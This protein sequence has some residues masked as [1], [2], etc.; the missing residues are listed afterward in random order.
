MKN[1]IYKLVLI[2]SLFLAVS[3]ADNALDVTPKDANFPFQ[4]ILDTDEGGDLADAEDY[5]IEIKFADYLGN[6][7]SETITLSYAI[8]AEDSFEGIVEIDKVVYEVEIDDCV[9]ERELAFD[10]IAK[11][12]TVVQ[13]QDLESLP[14][15]FEVIV[16]LPGADDTEGGFSFTITSIQSSNTNIVVGEPSTFD[17]EVVDNDVAGE[18]IWE[19]TSADD[20]ESFKEVFA[21]VSP[22]LA[23]LNFEDIL[24]D[25][26]VR[27][28]RVQFEY[29]EMKFELEL[30]EEEEICE[31]G[32]LDT[33]NKQL[34]I[35]AEYDAEDGELVLEG[36]RLVL[37]EDDGEIEDELD[38]IVE[39]SYEID[40]E[41]G[42][43]VLT[44]VKVID[45]DNYEEGEELFTGVRSFTF[46]KD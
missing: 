21:I 8:E 25:E 28:I 27:T 11:T 46:I 22:D 10:P 26:G 32:E 2:G 33:E 34:E 13:D 15:S 16:L 3:C 38:F 39:A 9:Y 37:N 29:G 24:E 7:P 18:W 43:I 44:F 31:D 6:L 30:A 4:L 1:K 17:Y 40:E 41:S 5:G 45:E 42:H 35:E 23:E 19:L 20:F 12:I 14:E 36:S